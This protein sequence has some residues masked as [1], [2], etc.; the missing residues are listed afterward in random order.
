M[1][2][3]TIAPAWMPSSRNGHLVQGQ[4]ALRLPPFDLRTEKG[5]HHVR[6]EDEP[7]RRCGRAEAAEL[8][9]EPEHKKA[10]GVRA[11]VL[12]PGGRDLGSATARSP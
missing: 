4:Q 3:G 10:I 9:P 1:R 12:F 6:G 2:S 7:S 11:N 8:Q 5:L